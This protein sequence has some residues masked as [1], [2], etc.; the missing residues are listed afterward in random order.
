MP[1]QC[2][3][4]TWA[5]WAVA[6]WQLNYAQFAGLVASV[7]E[8]PC[9]LSNTNH[10][11]SRI[12]FAGINTGVL[13]INI[14]HELIHKANMFEQSLGKILLVTVSVL[15]CLLFY[16][17]GQVCY[18]HFYVEHIWGHHK[19]VSTSVG[20]CVVC[21]LCNTTVQIQPHLDWAKIST[22]FGRALLLGVSGVVSSLSVV[23]VHC[24]LSIVH[25]ACFNNEQKRMAHRS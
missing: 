7:G 5:C 8:C 22:F 23:I 21:S 18:G 1:V 12:V 13:G 10:N 2:A 4:I 15:V 14:A 20:A 6:T 3:F 9:C 25:C 19:H 16:R 24:S 11:S 17:M